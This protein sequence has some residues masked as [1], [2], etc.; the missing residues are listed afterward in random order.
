[1]QSHFA[2]YSVSPGRFT[3]MP[4]TSITD[5]SQELVETQRNSH[6]KRWWKFDETQKYTVRQNA[7]LSQYY[8][9]GGAWSYQS[10]RF[11]EFS[12]WEVCGLN[13]HLLAGC[14]THGKTSWWKWKQVTARNELKLIYHIN[15]DA[16]QLWRQSFRYSARIQ[17]VTKLL[18][19]HQ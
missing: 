10:L 2:V 16:L 19:L 3:L 4:S 17:R 1:M 18:S 13:Q 9:R 7:R 8:G 12:F 14:P 5:M 11:E 6:C 15:T